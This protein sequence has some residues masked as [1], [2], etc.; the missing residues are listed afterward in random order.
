MGFYPDMERVDA[1][2]QYFKLPQDR[3]PFSVIALGYSTDEN[4][5]IDRSDMSKVHYNNW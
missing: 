5:F 3:I 1:I 2:R 4:K